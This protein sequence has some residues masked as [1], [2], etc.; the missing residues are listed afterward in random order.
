MSPKLTILVVLAIA[1]FLLVM[2][3]LHQDPRYHAFADQRTVF[4]IDNFCDVASNSLFLVVGLIGLLKFR[5]F[6]SRVLFFGVFATAVGSSY[7]HLRPDN[8]RL[9]WDRLPMA[10]AFMALFALA[11]R[12]RAWVLPLVA[13][14]IASV[15]W[16]RFT[17]NLWPYLL[18]QFGPM[19]PLMVIAWRREKGLWPVI[20]FYG[21]SKVAEGLDRQIYAVSPISGHT[22]KH[23]FAGIATWYIFC[24]VDSSKAVAVSTTASA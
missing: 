12:R 18:V 3:P 23:L 16:W 8:A 19:I 9:F 21:F 4:G 5:D 15:V 20:A 22:L 17:D 1:V 11:L 13:V 6:E 2:P 14:G 10:I 24:W 7:Y